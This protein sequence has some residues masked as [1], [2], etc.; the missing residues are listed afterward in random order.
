MLSRQN[1]LVGL[2][3]AHPTYA[4]LVRHGLELAVRIDYSAAR[5]MT[6]WFHENG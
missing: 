5:T 4:V 6:E 3:D 1:P 2:G